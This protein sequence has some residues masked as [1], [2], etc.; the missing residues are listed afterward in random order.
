MTLNQIFDNVQ[1]G[2]D[3][4]EVENN[5]L[6]I[7]TQNNVNENGEIYWPENSKNEYIVTCIYSEEAIQEE[8]EINIR[9]N[10]DVIL[11]S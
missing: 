5:K 2:E 9:L 6:T 7:S 11:Y 4:Y 3:S 1:F 10:S 8:T